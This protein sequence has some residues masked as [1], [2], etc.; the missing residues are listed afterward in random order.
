MTP[1]WPSSLEIY[2]TF[3]KSI[4]PGGR[5]HVFPMTTE[6]SH[7]CVGK[8]NVTQSAKQNAKQIKF[9]TIVT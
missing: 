4:V 3:P 7:A 8:S 9:A 2:M 1:S 5:A 6:A